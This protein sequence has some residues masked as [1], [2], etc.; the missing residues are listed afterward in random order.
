MKTLS[1]T[2]RPI[3]LGGLSGVEGLSGFSTDKCPVVAVFCCPRAVG[4]VHGRETVPVKSCQQAQSTSITRWTTLQIMLS[5]NDDFLNV[6]TMTFKKT[7]FGDVFLKD[8]T[9]R[10][11]FKR[12]HQTTSFFPGINPTD[13]NVESD[14]F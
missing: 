14:I 2:P 7:S 3:P 12:R 6:I 11:P 1:A 9:K 10:R 5:L 8:A 4:S 13:S